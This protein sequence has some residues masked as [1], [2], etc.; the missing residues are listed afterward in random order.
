MTKI[1]KMIQQT[2]WQVPA[3]LLDHFVTPGK[4]LVITKK[5]PFVIWLI[6]GLAHNIK[7]CAF[8]HASSQFTLNTIIY[9]Q[10]AGK[11][12]LRVYTG[13]TATVKKVI[14][15]VLI[16]KHTISDFNRSR[17]DI[18]HIYL[19]KLFRYNTL[20]QIDLA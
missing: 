10:Y 11:E 2:S 12:N 17:S 8:T 9:C 4:A 1:H 5:D 14:Y 15:H 7:S 13:Y 16:Q 6:L 3:S 20:C 19:H 18:F